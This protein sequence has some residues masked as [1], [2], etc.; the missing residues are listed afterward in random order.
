MVDRILREHGD[1]TSFLAY[2]EFDAVLGGLV[3]LLV[4][5]AIGVGYEF[6]PPEQ[7]P[8]RELVDMVPPADFVRSHPSVPPGTWSD[9]GAQA[10]CLLASLVECGE[11]NLED[12][13]IKLTSWMHF[14]YLAVDRQVFD[15]G[16]QTYEAMWR[17]LEDGVPAHLAGGDEEH[18]NGNGSLMRVLPLALWHRGSNEELV[19]VAH[20]QSLPTHRHPRSLVVC[21]LYSL[22]ARGYLH[23]EDDP[24]KWADSE[25][26]R[27]YDAWVQYH[28]RHC[29][30]KELD[31]V[32]D[33]PRQHKPSGTG[34]VVDTFWTAR[35]SMRAA[36][37]DDVIRTA[38]AFGHDTD[39]TACV[40]GGLAGIKFGLHAIPQQWL[41][42]LRG[43]DT[44]FEQFRMFIDYL[45]ATPT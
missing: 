8:P 33:F 45:E 21:A 4:G 15:V 3:G 28:Q 31:V 36:T 34:Y 14:G 23:G 25:L 12:F 41:R 20:D 17:M 29:L 24:W 11:F 30:K 40:A 2:Q 37:F 9:D 6:N 7:L 39:T 42:T 5:D 22:V 27:V 38:I 10:M 1:F 43:F 26:E 44:G 35:E 32:R 19:Q 18:E 16:I 13:G